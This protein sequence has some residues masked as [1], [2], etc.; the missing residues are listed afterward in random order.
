MLIIEFDAEA[1][2]F[3]RDA[4]AEAAPESEEED[5]VETDYES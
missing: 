2:F 5:P 4:E 1:E 3:K